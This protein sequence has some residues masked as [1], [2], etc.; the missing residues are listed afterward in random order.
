MAMYHSG[1]GGGGIGLVH[2][3]EASQPFTRNREVIDFREMAPGA[4]SEDMF[5]G[6]PKSS[7]VGGLAVFVSPLGGEASG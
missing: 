6:N 2:W 3:T 7:K 1:I 5:V 4:A